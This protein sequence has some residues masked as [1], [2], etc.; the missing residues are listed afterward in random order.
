MTQAAS[1]AGRLE[2]ALA[3]AAGGDGRP[4][5][6]VSFTLDYGAAGEIG[7]ATFAARVDRATRSLV[8]VHGEAVLADGRR[9]ASASGVFRV[10]ET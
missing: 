9:L 3:D 8:F 4:V 2:Q 1:L 5:S 6:P 10:K 7:E